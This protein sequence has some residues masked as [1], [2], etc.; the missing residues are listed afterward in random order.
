MPTISGW[1]VLTSF[2]SWTWHTAAALGKAGP[3]PLAG[4]ALRFLQ[5]Y[6]PE[7]DKSLTLD[8]FKVHHLYWLMFTVPGSGC[9]S[10]EQ[11]SHTVQETAELCVSSGE[12]GVCPETARDL[13]LGCSCARKPVAEQRPAICKVTFYLRQQ[14][15]P[16]SHLIRFPAPQP[17]SMTWQ[18]LEFQLTYWATTKAALL[19]G[20]LKCGQPQQVVLRSACASRAGGTSI[21]LHASC[22][23]F[24]RGLAVHVSGIDHYAVPPLTHVSVFCFTLTQENPVQLLAPGADAGTW[25]LCWQCTA[26]HVPLHPA[27][28]LTDSGL[29]QQPE[30]V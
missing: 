15:M 17:D 25:P 18:T 10:D 2:V 13:Q 20:P 4:R 8:F 28:S 5:E 3:E 22:G 29:T 30:G 21:C 24:V 16:A 11:P 7:E 23:R 1:L 9:S 27:A 6:A 14:T 26:G 12:C 19:R